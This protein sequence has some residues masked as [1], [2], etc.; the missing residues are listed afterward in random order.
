MVTVGIWRIVSVARAESRSL[1]KATK[2]SA[3]FRAYQARR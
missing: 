3:E 2:V 1:G